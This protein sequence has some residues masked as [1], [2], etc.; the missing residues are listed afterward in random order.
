MFLYR[1]VQIA[2]SVGTEDSKE[3]SVRMRLRGVRRGD[4]ETEGTP[5]YPYSVRSVLSVRSVRSVR[6]GNGE[7]EEGAV[8]TQSVR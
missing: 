2:V 1:R 5:P 8:V 4:G 3:G 7:V 6:V